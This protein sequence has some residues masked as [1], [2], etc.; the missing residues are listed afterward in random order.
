M[1][2]WAAKDKDAGGLKAIAI[3]KAL[4]PGC[5]ALVFHRSAER[6]VTHWRET[7]QVADMLS[8]CWTPL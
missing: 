3:I 8:I 2:L 5:Q 1:A 6:L 7:R 4:Q